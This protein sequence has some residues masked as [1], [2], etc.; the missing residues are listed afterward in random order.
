STAPE[1]TYASASDGTTYRAGRPPGPAAAIVVNVAA[2]R[3]GRSAGSTT[4]RGRSPDISVYS[5]R[6]PV[7]R[8]T[9]WVA[10]TGVD[11]PACPG[12]GAAPALAPAAVN[13][14]A[15]AATRQAIAVVILATCRGVRTGFSFRRVAARG[16]RDAAVQEVRRRRHGGRPR[17]Q[18]PLVTTY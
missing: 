15:V 5:T 8:V 14:A 2:G 9:V 3:S 17:W 10:P 13:A 16:C 12:A 6:S 4:T 7:S 11:A 1:A 18:A